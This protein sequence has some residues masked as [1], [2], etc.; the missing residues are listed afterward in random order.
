MS[1]NV[2]G[3]LATALSW[4]SSGGSAVLTCTSVANAAGRLGARLDLGA[5]PRPMTYK[6]Y[7]EFQCQA[8]PTV[9]NL[10]RLYLAEWDDESG[11]SDPDGDV[12]ASDAGFAT[13]NDLRNLNQ[14]GS[15]IVDAASANVVFSRSGL[16]QITKR[17]VSPVVWNASGAALTATASHH[18]IMLT[19]VFDQIQ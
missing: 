5:A 7:A 2:Y 14:I 3:S 16:I 12:G 10:I 9:G 1:N 17:Y 15:V 8:T 18:Y 19:P 6:W 4:K 11:P 13:E